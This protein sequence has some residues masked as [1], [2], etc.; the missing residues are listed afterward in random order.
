M[1]FTTS[2]NTFGGSIWQA[3]RAPVI[4]PA[5][6]IIVVT[7]NGSFNGVTD[8]GDSVL[9]LSSRDLSLLDWFTPDNWSALC[10]DDK[11]LGSAGAILIRGTNQLLTAGKPGDLLLLN[12][13]SMGHL[14]AM[15][16]Q[17]L[18]ATQNE[19][20]DFALWNQPDSA[21]A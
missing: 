8:F 4:D 5:G 13:E 12:V 20:Y 18:Q 14:A 15:N 21:I 3:G 2:P 9:K 11:D 19:I 1:P 17:N 16:S 6:N 10:E 7:S